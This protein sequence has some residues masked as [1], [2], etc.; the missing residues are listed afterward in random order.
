MNWLEISVRVDS[1]AVESVADLFRRYGQGGVVVE[2]DITP[3]SEQE[4]YVVNLDKPVTVRTYV[5]CN[6][7]ASRR[8]KQI[9]RGLW[10]LR[11]IRPMGE[12]EVREVAEEDWANAWKAHFD[13]HRVGGRIVIK[14]SW[15]EYEPEP[16]DIVVELD[17]GMAFG[18]GLHPTTRLCLGELEKR[19]TPGSTVL[20]L[21]TGSGILAIAA[22]KLGAQAVTALDLDEVAVKVARD[23]VGA[24]GVGSLVIVSKGTLKAREPGLG[25]PFGAGTFDVVVAN[26]LANVIVELAGALAIVL[27]PGGA[28]IA[29]GIIEEHASEARLAIERA[30]LVIIADRV[31]GDWHAMVAEKHA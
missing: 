25:S 12:M 27:K 8:R 18:T 14:P 16:E 29:S 22:A 1:E 11:A 5:R 26:I 31:E 9:E 7:G 4:N 20:D 6:A 30:N 3:L 17:P 21:G 2:E 28:L 19:L 23:N 10:H 13:V 15:R 24:N